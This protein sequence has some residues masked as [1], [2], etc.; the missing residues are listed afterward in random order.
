MIGI[1]YKIVLSG[2]IGV[3]KSNILQRYYRGV[4]TGQVPTIGVEFQTKLVKINDPDTGEETNI[5]AQIWD[6]SGSER[7]RSIVIGHYRAAVGAV[8]VLDITDRETFVVLDHW[9]KELRENCDEY[10]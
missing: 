1:N 10:C 2:H 5:C 4:F 9:L 8:L 6:T 3:G 7:Y